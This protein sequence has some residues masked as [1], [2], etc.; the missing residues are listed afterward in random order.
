MKIGQRI[1]AERKRQFVGRDAELEL[2]RSALLSSAFPFSLLYLHGPGGVGKTTLLQSFAELC[3]DCDA[4]PLHLDA[5]NIEP[6]PIVFL[7]TLRT[8]LELPLHADPVAFLGASVERRVVLLDTFELLDGMQV[9]FRDVFL[10]QLSTNVLLITAGRQSPQIAWPLDSSWHSVLRSIGLQN[11]SRDESRAYLERRTFPLDNQAAA[12][13]FTHGHPLALSLL[14]DLHGS[15]PHVA[16][17]SLF[18]DK[19]A[20]PEVVDT[21][22]K[23]FMAETP[24]G[25]R[26]SALEVCAVLRVTNETL[27]REI[28]FPAT[29]EPEPGVS[30]TDEDARSLF[31]WLRSLSFVDAGPSGLFLHDIAREA[32]L[33]DL[34]WRDPDWYSELHHRARAH[35]VHQLQQA[36][37][38]TAQKRS[39]YD[40]VFLHRD[41]PIVRAAFTWQET[42]EVFADRLNDNDIEPIVKMVATHEGTDAAQAARY[43]LQTQPDATVVFRANGASRAKEQEPV[44]FFT[45]LGLHNVCEADFAADPAAQIIANHIKA[46]SPLRENEGATCLRFWIAPNTTEAASPLQSLL[47]VHILR[48]FLTSGQRLAYTFFCCSDPQ[49]WQAVFDYAE[50]PFVANYPI[51]DKTGAIFGRDWRRAPLS[52]WLE[53]IAGKETERGGTEETAAPS[54]HEKK[55]SAQVAD[56]YATLTEVQFA[57]AVQDALRHLNQPEKLRANLLLRSHLF[58]ATAYDENRGTGALASPDALKKLLHD[59]AESLNRPGVQRK[60]AYLALR[61]TYLTPAATQDAAADRLGLPFST[62]RRHLAEGIAALSAALWDKEISR[63][64]N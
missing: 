35:Y 7:D 53:T 40:C 46:T 36:S 27:L 57:I 8:A 55:T 2:L 20:S 9:W 4:L 58:A 22:L 14:A 31:V 42:S 44:A 10:P 48:H 19:M 21:L 5:R 45:M 34:R 1:V 11:F 28:L 23:R 54:A 24:R 41:S 6:T 62:Y 52:R 64:G 26:K 33:A 60:R 17:L 32:L 49:A 39:L 30:F 18:A 15:L 59:T 50:I 43:W 61:H 3:R 29:S 63:S 47:I 16:E 25:L 51:G 37:G 13:D 38:E 12:I 56:T